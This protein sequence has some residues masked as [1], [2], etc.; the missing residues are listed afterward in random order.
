M[1]SVQTN[2]RTSE[3]KYVTV[4]ADGADGS[5][6]VDI[7]FREP[8][9]SRPSDHYMVGVDNL[10]VN[11]NHLPMLEM[12][13]D[14]VVFE[15]G[16]F[17][18]NAAATHFDPLAGT[19]PLQQL[20][21]G[22][23][24]LVTDVFVAAEQ[25]K[26]LANYQNIQQLVLALQ[27]FFASVN[28]R[29]QAGPDVLGGFP[30]VGVVVQNDGAAPVPGPF[31]AA[32]VA[33]DK[34]TTHIQCVLSPSGQ[35]RLI[36][37]RAFWSNYFIRIPLAKHQYMLEG[38]KTAAVYDG[39]AKIREAFKYLA[40]DADGAV[41]DP[42]SC[43]VLDAVAPAQILFVNTAPAGYPVAHNRG[44]IGTPATLANLAYRTTLKQGVFGASLLGSA[45]R[46]IAMEMGCSLPIV[47]NPLVDHNKESPD[48][49]VG[50]WMWNS[51][52]R[53]SALSTGVNM[54]FSALAPAVFEF[55]NAT[56]RVQFHSLMPQDKI[57]TLRL[58]LYCRVRTYNEARDRFDME[59]VVMPMSYT[60]WWH[61]RLHF[62]SKD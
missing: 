50:R 48:F 60:D 25:F 58:K 32:I 42:I 4:M 41:F 8:L 27:E 34:L 46:R 11:L 16:R 36:G 28:E 51:Q 20:A 38:K 47:N 23:G 7:S 12:N 59:T 26:I 39:P 6:D 19:T 17:T 44:I 29:I 37:S 53:L 54:E 49:T 55:Q 21:G 35:L 10:T 31:T 62:V 2:K 45:E 30:N 5:P 22:A 57:H 52:S 24:E 43:D 15:L 13:A 1:A 40:L 9:L 3:S 56:D 14:E 33:A 18:T 61:C